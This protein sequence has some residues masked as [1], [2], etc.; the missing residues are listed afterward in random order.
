MPAIPRRTRVIRRAAPLLRIWLLRL[1]LV[2]G[3]FA[4]GSAWSA[5]PSVVTEAARLEQS[6]VAARQSF[7]QAPTNATLAWQCGRACF[8]RAEFAT[9]SAERALLAGQGIAACRRAVTLAPNSAAAHHYLAMN[10]GQLART[11]LLGAL[12]L[13]TEM[14]AEFKA[15]RRLDEHL[16]FAGPDRSL[17][18][19][20]LEAPGWPTSVGSRTKARQHLRRAAELAPQYPENRLTLL[21]AYLRWGDHNGVQREL[22]ALEEIWPAARTNFAGEPW[23]AA[24]ADWETRLKRAKAAVDEFPKPQ[25]S[26]RR[27]D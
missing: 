3:G 1:G 27:S 6:L 18:L 14:E 13:V 12:K 22:K 15:A 7:L 17:G 20:Y 4:P 11:K 24:W 16:D 26:P 23:A 19:L 25:S 9:N 21:E 10:L 2:I 8:D 5:A